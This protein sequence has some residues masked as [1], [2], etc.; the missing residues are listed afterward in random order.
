MMNFALD[1]HAEPCSPAA[2]GVLRLK[3]PNLR[4]ITRHNNGRSGQRFTILLEQG[5]QTGTVRF[6]DQVDL[7]P[8]RLDGAVTSPIISMPVRW[9]GWIIKH[10][11]GLGVISSM[12]CIGGWDSEMKSIYQDA[13]RLDYRVT[14]L[15]T[16]WLPFTLS[17]L[18]DIV[19]ARTPGKNPI[20]RI[21]STVEP[22]D[23]DQLSRLIMTAGKSLY[24]LHLHSQPHPSRITLRDL[25]AVVRLFRTR[26]P[27]LVHLRLPMS[28][29]VGGVPVLDS[30]IDCSPSDFASGPGK[31]RVLRILV[32]DLGNRQPKDLGASFSW[33]FARNMASLLA[34]DFELSIAEGPVSKPMDGRFDQAG[35]N[36][37][38]YYQWCDNL[39]AAIKFFQK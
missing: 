16:G 38:E 23:I 5:K 33:D 10:T 35:F 32:Y 4:V 36:S 19:S 8:N 34:P 20:S 21:S 13:N 22:F 37:F 39:K 24:Q 12:G 9:Q 31:I 7:V 15:Q 6:H 3:C 28:L 18:G 14:E 11:V 2:I 29:S 17:E 25:P 26:C 1:D 30:D 27:K